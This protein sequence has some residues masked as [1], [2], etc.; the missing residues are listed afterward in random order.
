[1]GV[2]GEDLAIDEVVPKQELNEYKKHHRGNT[3]P[4]ALTQGSLF[5]KDTTNELFH[6]TEV[7][8]EG[9][10]VWQGEVLCLNNEIL[11]LNNEVLFAPI[12]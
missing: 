3:I 4:N 11:V 5:S 2:N 6:T 9:P 1:M 8:V 10:R 12:I 7:G